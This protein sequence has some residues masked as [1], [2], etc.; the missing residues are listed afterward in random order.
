MEGVSSASGIK[1]RPWP[2]R[3]SLVHEIVKAAVLFVT[4]GRLTALFVVELEVQALRCAEV[5]FSVIHDR[6]FL[7]CLLI[8]NTTPTPF[9]VESTGV[10]RYCVCTSGI[11]KELGHFSGKTKELA[12][13]FPGM[14]HGL[15]ALGCRLSAVGRSILNRPTIC[16]LKDIDNVYLHFT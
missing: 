13:P 6:H 12:G 1:R 15:T 16:Y 11:T 7:K 10:T 5:F 9:V 14:V 8:D 3:C 2:G 4:Q